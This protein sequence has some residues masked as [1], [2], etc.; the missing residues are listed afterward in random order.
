MFGKKQEFN[1]PEMPGVC[2]SC[3]ELE[4]RSTAKFVFSY[5]SKLSLVATALALCAGVIY[6]HSMVYRLEL[7]VCGACS[8]SLGRSKVVAVLGF[9]LFLP[10]LVLMLLLSDSPAIVLGATLVYLVATPIYYAVLRRRGTPKVARIGND[11]LA[12]AIP[13]YG[14]FVLLEPEHKAGR[15]PRRQK[16]PAAPNLNRSV[17]DGCG[18][19][20]F[21][22]VLECKKC[23]A[24]LG[25]AVAV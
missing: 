17:C 1:L 3:G 10:M 18:F 16:A 9:V 8:S 14:E 2:L 24:P 11:H 23:H 12:L 5:T 22:N 25:Q 6:T 21:P 13:D 19:I 4:P 20:N 7:P 15:Q